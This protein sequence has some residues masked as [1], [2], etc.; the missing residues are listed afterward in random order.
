MRK[1]IC[2]LVFGLIFLAASTAASAQ[3][4]NPLIQGGVQ[5]VEL[6]PQFICHAAIFSGLFHGQVGANPNALGIITAAMTHEDLPTV[7]GERVAITGGAWELKTLTRRIRGNVVGG[8][9]TYVGGNFFAI[10]V[11]LDLQSGGNGFVGF[12]GF[13]NHN[14]PIPTFEGALV[15]LQ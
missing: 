11:A 1:A 7:E 15:Q 12:T 14:T 5:G 2:V 13:L 6:C 4:S 9:I 3:S 10:R 8:S